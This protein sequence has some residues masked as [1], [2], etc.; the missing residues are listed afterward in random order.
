MLYF[1]RALCVAL[2]DSIFCTCGGIC[3]ELLQARLFHRASRA[4]GCTEVIDWAKLWT[5]ALVIAAAWQYEKDLG[6]GLAAIAK[7][8]ATDFGPCDP[9]F[10]TFEVLATFLVYAAVQSLMYGFLSGIV[11][12]ARGY[13]VCLALE[14]GMAGFGFYL[15]GAFDIPS[16]ECTLKSLLAGFCSSMSALTVAAPLVLWRALMRRR[17]ESLSGPLSSPQDGSI[18]NQLLRHSESSSYSS[19]RDRDHTAA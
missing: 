2:F 16:S 17:K 9:T 11:L 18:S 12:R 4:V 10:S 7:R 14:V 8:T 19:G 5:T 13:E 6:H 1:G 3:A 15:A